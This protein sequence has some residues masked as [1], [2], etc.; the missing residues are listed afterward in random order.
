[1]VP[2]QLGQ[3]WAGLGW[4]RA[5]PGG[6]SSRA[7]SAGGRA[8]GGGG[9]LPHLGPGRGRAEPRPRFL[10]LPAK[11][12][13][14]TPGPGPGSGPPCR[15]PPGRRCERLVREGPTGGSWPRSSPRAPYSRRPPLSVLP[16][17]VGMSC[18]CIQEVSA[19]RISSMWKWVSSPGLEKTLLASLQLHPVQLLVSTL[20]CFCF[21]FSFPPPGDSGHLPR[22]A[23]PAP[24]HL[25]GSPLQFLQNASRPL[26]ARSFVV[27]ESGP[28]AGN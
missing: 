23:P 13:A 25:C 5:A 12:A 2:G 26:S 6:T 10:R 16:G 4:E 18:C 9:C 15:A 22:P 7:G 20:V 8:G 19:S 1:M 14:G 17:N 21:V 11:S 27:A 24:L 28:L 3:C